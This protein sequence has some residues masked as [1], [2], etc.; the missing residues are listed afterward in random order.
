MFLWSIKARYI[1]EIDYLE[2]SNGKLQAWEIKS[3]PQARA[4]IPLTFQKAYP[5]AATGILNPGNY[6]DFLLP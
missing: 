1:L 6:E 4:K 2:E 5:D 3:N